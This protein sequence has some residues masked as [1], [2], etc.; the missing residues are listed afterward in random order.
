MIIDLSQLPNKVSQTTFS[1]V[2]ELGTSITRSHTLWIDEKGKL[3]LFGSNFYQFGTY[4]GAL[5]FDLNAD[6]LHPKYLGNYTPNSGFYIHDGFV[7]GDTLWASEIYDGYE[8]VIDVSDPA[9]GESLARFPT[10]SFF[11]H[12]SWPTNND[13]YV[14]TT[15]EVPGSYLTAYDVHNL[16]NVTEV[17]RIQHNPGS[18]PIIHN[19]HLLSDSFAVCSYYTEG[20]LIYDVT[21]PDDMVE[22]GHYDL[23]PAS[24]SGFFNG[25][26]GVYPYLPSH[27]LIAS[28]IEDGLYVLTPHYQH[29]WWLRGNIT[30]SS[31]SAPIFKADIKVLGPSLEDSSDLLG[32][33]KTG[34]VTAGTFDVQISKPKYV[35]KTIHGVQ[36]ENGK[37]TNLD[38][39]LVP[40]STFN[41]DMQI[42]DSISNDPLD[43]VQVQISD[44]SGLNYSQTAISDRNGRITME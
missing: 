3:Y 22:V 23:Y 27:T 10:T 19:V 35:T 37:L 2:P 13:H 39:A 9:N 34:S 8:E 17:D 7:R 11:T 20:A 5:I 14:F 24:N 30:D 26:W 44:N 25:T 38:V 43:S 4:T 18:N 1:Y 36:F 6:P 32:N 28:N 21:Y 29:A 15:D 12:N 41:A 16:S 31:T 40:A 33:Y 42:L